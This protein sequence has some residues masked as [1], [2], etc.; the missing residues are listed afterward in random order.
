MVSIKGIY[1]AAYKALHPD[2]DIDY[3]YEIW[4]ETKK[5]GPGAWELW[6]QTETEQQ[7]IAFCKGS[8]GTYQIQKK[9]EFD[10]DAPIY[11]N[12]VKS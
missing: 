5:Q 6:H 10:A 2:Y 8:L 4:I 12:G 11:I 3:Q 1:L 9:N 7:A